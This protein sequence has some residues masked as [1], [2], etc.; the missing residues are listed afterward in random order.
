VLARV[1]DPPELK[2]PSE[3]TL[4]LSRGPYLL[5]EELALMRSHEADVLVTKNSGGTH[6]QAKL[7]AADELG[8]PVVVV[9]RPPAPEGVE[10]VA[11]V[12]SAVAW[13]EA[14]HLRVQS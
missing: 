13:V 2:V 8:I 4:L 11:D 5:D 6:T 14:H 3:W 7:E 9:R 12:A 10:S 1:V